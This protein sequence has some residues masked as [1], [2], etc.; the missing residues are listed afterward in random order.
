MLIV[1]A[2][3]AIIGSVMVGFDGHRG[4]VYYLAV[5]PSRAAAGC[6]R[7]LMA[8]AE[9]W[10]AARGCPKIQLMVRDGNE[11]AA[12]FYQR[13]ASNASRSRPGGA[14]EA[15]RAMI[16]L[17]GIRNCDTVKKARAWLT[18]AG[19]EL[20]VPQLQ[21]VEGVDPARLAAWARCGR[22]GSAAQPRGHD[23]PQARRSRSRRYRRGEGAA[24][25]GRRIHR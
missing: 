23:V 6:G 21:A 12:G 3:D 10:L 11:E 1:R 9:A 16:H 15:G 17:Y 19:V 7:A 20:C 13:S 14:S 24:A 4:W 25:D 8:A 5:G 22:V 18:A 2:T